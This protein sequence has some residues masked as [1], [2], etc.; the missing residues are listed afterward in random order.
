MAERHDL[1]A[2]N[3]AI[4]R[5]E[6]L[7]PL[8]FRYTNETQ[9]LLMHSEMVISEMEESFNQE[10]QLRLMEERRVE[11]EYV[12]EL[13]AYWNGK[14]EA[15]H[16]IR[17]ARD[18]LKTEQDEQYHTWHSHRREELQALIDKEH[19]KMKTLRAKHAREMRLVQNRVEAAELEWKNEKQAENK[20]FEEVVKE[21]FTMLQ[22]KEQEE[23]LRSA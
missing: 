21:R 9:A 23:Y 19:E 7:D 6:S 18:D 11:Y 16:R 13:F 2:E 1:E 3:L 15:E 20:W 10:Y 4:D 12:E 14:P 8:S 17:Q 5:Q 22:A